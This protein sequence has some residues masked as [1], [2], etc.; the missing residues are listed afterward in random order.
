MLLGVLLAVLS[1]V[2]VIYIVSQATSTAGQTM[3]VVVAKQDIPSNTVLTTGATDS[4]HNLLNIQDAFGVQSYPASLVPPNAFIYTSVADLQ[5]HLNNEVVFSEI[6]AGDVLRNSDPRLQL[7]GTGAAGSMTGINPNALKP[8]DVLISLDFSN[9]G[10]NTRNFVVPGDYVD[11]LVTECSL[12]NIPGCVTQTT[13]QNVYI[14]ATFT[15]AVVVV[16]NHEQALQ[17]K[18][19]TETGKVNLALRNPKE[20]GPNATADNTTPVTA[21]SISAAFGF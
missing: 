5:V 16:V 3:Q 19:M 8:G 7:L 18:Y 20:S 4:T 17:L 9:P 12:P 11:I 6:F 10:G 1:G 13:L 15:N 2:L 14:Y 21:A